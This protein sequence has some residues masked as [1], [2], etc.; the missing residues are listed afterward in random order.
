MAPVLHEIN[1]Y[2]HYFFVPYR[3][4][5]PSTG[6]NDSGGWDEFITGGLLGAS[7]LSL[8]KWIPTDA[9][10]TWRY[11][12]WDYLGFP[13]NT[14][15]LY[16]GPVYPLD[17][18]R[19]AYYKVWNDFYRDETLQTEL[20][21]TSVSNYAI[22]SRNWQKD[23]FTS[24]L[25]WQQR[26]TPPA[27]PI[28]GGSAIF[29]LS[30][31]AY[32]DTQSA[33]TV[34]A[35]V[36]STQFHASSAMAANNLVGALNNN[37]LSAGITFNV[38]DL[39]LLFQ[40]QRWMERNARA[41]VRYTE[42]LQS[43]FAVSPRDERLQRPEY[44]GGSRSPIIISEVLQTSQTGT[45]PQGNMAGHGI[46]V[47]RGFCGKYHVQEF[48]LIIGL[49]S[50]MPKPMY[51]P[52]GFNR[53]WLRTTRYDFPFPEFSHL[54]EQA[55]TNAEIAVFNTSADNTIFGYQGR[56]DECRV[57]HSFV[58]G[59]MRSSMAYWHLARVFASAPVLGDTFLQCVPDKR[60]F[61]DTIDPG[62]IVHFGNDL[63]VIRPLPVTP[64]PGLIDHD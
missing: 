24:S 47:N 21:I 33:V 40:V 63:K 5:W 16:A 36:S 44:I 52:Q 3:L 60:I 46:G 32:P 41:G 25:P 35:S 54:S 18:P 12:L 48:G 56:Y 27:L 43:H 57:K 20:D 10:Q 28:T 13:I 29:D 19:R 59:S 38:S 8:P 64:E 30:D 11:T 22:K 37:V 14:N 49:L 26:G 53:Q 58:A 55:I 62:L 61:A 50:I 9:A 39:R 34:H 6:S 1:A 2:V 4:L 17:F 31:V 7:T 23:Y 15:V 51:Y 42:F 45:T